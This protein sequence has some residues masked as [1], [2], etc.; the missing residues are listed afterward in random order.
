MAI[1]VEE[2]AKPDLSPARA[3]A[4]LTTL[5]SVLLLKERRS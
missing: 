2:H 3:L 5:R 1:S 4:L